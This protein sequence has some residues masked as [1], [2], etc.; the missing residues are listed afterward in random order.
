MTQAQPITSFP[1]LRTDYARL[2]AAFSIAELHACV[3][4]A[5]NVS[6]EA[7]Q[8][9]EA[10]LRAI[11]SHPE[12]PVAAV[13]GQACLLELEGIL[14][15]CLRCAV[16]GEPLKDNPSWFSPQAGGL[17]AS[18]VA[19]DYNDRYLVRAEALIGIARIAELDV[20]PN[21]LKF[22]QECL[23]ALGPYWKAVAH[24][25]VPATDA[26]IESLDHAG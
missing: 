14:P 12:P 18:S 1:G 11:E 22:A 6:P 19:N 16:T 9:L 8:L 26:Y 17:V 7:F 10:T 13:W 20:P 3:A 21:R 2:S 5:G 4:Q 23:R 24:A 15:A 25:P